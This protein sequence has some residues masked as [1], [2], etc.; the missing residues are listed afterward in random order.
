MMLMLFSS[1][2]SFV[3]NSVPIFVLLVSF[4]NYPALVVPALG[5][6]DFMPNF[7]SL[8][9]FFGIVSGNEKMDSVR[10]FVPSVFVKIIGVD[11]LSY[12]VCNRRVAIVGYL[13]HFPI[14]NF[15]HQSLAASAFMR[16]RR[17]ALRLFSYLQFY[18]FSF[19]FFPTD[20]APFRRAL[21]TNCRPAEIRAGEIRVAEIRAVEIRAGEI[22]VVEIRVAEIRVAEIRAGEI[23]VAEIRAGEIRVAEIRA[24][25]IRAGEIRVVEIRVAE[26]NVRNLEF[27]R[28][29]P[30]DPDGDWSA[31]KNGPVKFHFLSLLLSLL[32][33]LYT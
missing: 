23:R 11:E 26:I 28:T 18:D 25:E 20:E 16:R 9:I 2:I 27:F 3:C 7:F 29:H 30:S 5:A 22:R 8:L 33:C 21:H 19:D 14:V 10:A 24:V 13:L 1:E 4:F 6:V 32:V 15:Q 31:V 12:F 17:A